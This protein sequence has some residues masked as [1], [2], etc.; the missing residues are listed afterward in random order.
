GANGWGSDSIL[1]VSAGGAFLAEVIL[2]AIF[3]FVVLTMTR[4][5]ENKAVAGIPMGFTL[6]FVHIFGV[7]IDGTW[8]NPARSVGPALITGGTPLRQVWLFILAPL[9]G[10]VLAAGVHLLMHPDEPGSAEQ[11]ADPRAPSGAPGPDRPAGP[12]SSAGP[13]GP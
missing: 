13:A 11:I 9:V 12:A 1:H 4:P 8:V 2:T 5:G 6:A 3:V 7:P 10:A